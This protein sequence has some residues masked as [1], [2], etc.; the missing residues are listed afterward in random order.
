MSG[1]GRRDPSHP[2]V[3]DEPVLEIDRIQGNVLPGFNKPLQV[4]LFLEILNPA[5]FRPW[6]GSLVP[7]I[8]AAEEVLMF[9][10]ALRLRRRHGRT[11]APKATWANIAF[12]HPGLRHL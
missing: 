11:P 9:R 10:Q 2:R 8:T 5:Q 12:S 7:L 6:L 1:G 4:F 3:P